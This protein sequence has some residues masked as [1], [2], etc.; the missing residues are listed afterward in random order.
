MS[1]LRQVDVDPANVD[2]DGLC[3]S[4]SAAGAGNLTLNGALI[5]GGVFTESGAFGR[6]LSITSAGN[7]SGITFTITGTCPDGVAQTEIITG[8]NATTVEGSSYFRTVTS[9]AVSGAT[10]STVTVGTVDEVASKTYPLNTR[11]SDAATIAV[12]VTGTVNYTVQETFEDVLPMTSPAQ[13]TTWFNVTALASK[14][15]D[16]ASA[17]TRGASAVRLVFNSYTDGAEIQMSISEGF[18]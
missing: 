4:Q 13:N 14:T 8:P 7:D 6:Q 9:I 12:D 18:I 17:V 16:T 3:A 10:A 11:S 15:A 2:A 1:R 5:S